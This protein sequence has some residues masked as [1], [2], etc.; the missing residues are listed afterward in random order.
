MLKNLEMG[1]FTLLKPN[2]IT[3]KMKKQTGNRASR[4]PAQSLK[5]RSALNIHGTTIETFHSSY[6]AKKYPKVY[7]C[8]R[9]RRKTP[10]QK[11]H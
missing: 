2:A 7:L 9:K 1:P 5:E 3:E 4:R 6:S 8:D 11:N 10:I